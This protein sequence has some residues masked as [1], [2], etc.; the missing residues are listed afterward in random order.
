MSTYTKNLMTENGWMVG[1][2]FGRA[3]TGNR[4]TVTAAKGV[5]GKAKTAKNVALFLGAP[6]VGLVYLLAFP[7]V[8]FALLAWIAAKAVMNNA[9]ARPVA[10]ALAA[11]FI[12]LAFVTVG[13]I[14]GLGAF[15][16]F[17]GKALLRV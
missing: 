4:Y 6:F 17:G 14:V 15:V 2:G 3:Y 12:G 13:P 5:T 11:P 7:V 9:K 10:L 8:G 16:W 1:M